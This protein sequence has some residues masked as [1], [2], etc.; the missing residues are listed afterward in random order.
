VR[1]RGAAGRGGS[2]DA[3]VAVLTAV[4]VDPAAR[5]SGAGAAL[6]TEFVDVARAGGAD[7]VDL[8]TLSGHDG[9]ARFY[10]EMGWT[11][12]G[13][14]QDMDGHEVVTYRIEL[15]EPTQ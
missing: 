7:R 3:I 13:T 12:V 15:G 10:E 5:G 9:A 6:V 11:R 4:V 1:S 14:H 8:V 2:T